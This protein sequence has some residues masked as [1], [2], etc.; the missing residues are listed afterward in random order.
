MKYDVIKEDKNSHDDIGK[1]MSERKEPKRKHKNQT[2]NWQICEPPKNINLEV[3]LH[4][5]QNTNLEK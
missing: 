5:P 3:L 4:N 1:I 2:Y